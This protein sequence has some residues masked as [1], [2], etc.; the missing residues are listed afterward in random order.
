MHK[1]EFQTF[2]QRLPSISYSMVSISPPMVIHTNEKET[3]QSL[4]QGSPVAPPLH[5]E[6][7]VVMKNY[8]GTP[9]VQGIAV[10]KG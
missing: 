1:A 5:W 7:P 8:K 6:R 4:L 10:K 2:Y 3:N 9:L